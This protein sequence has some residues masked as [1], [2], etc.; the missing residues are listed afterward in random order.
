MIFER[1]YRVLLL[2]YP[3]EYRHRYGGSDGS[4]VSRPDAPGRWWIP[5]VSYLGADSL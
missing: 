4:A 2:T 1:V 3:T 5:N